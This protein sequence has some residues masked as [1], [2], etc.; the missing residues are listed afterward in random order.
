V[1]FL[2]TNVFIRYL[3]RD[4]EKKAAA[5]FELFQRVKRGA[6]QVTTCEAIV[7]EV[8]YVLSSRATYSLSHAEVRARLL[9]L[10]G[11]R[12]L[13]LP[14]KRVYQRALDIYVDQPALDFEDALLG[15]HMQRTK[16][17]ELYSYD[18]DF[19]RVTEVRRVE[20]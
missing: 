9:P 13:K 8:V 10:L 1:R 12:G 14:N 6:E 11:L 20:P 7:T 5:C 15:A 4:D 2:D 17:R 19:D 3:T 16:W 18:R